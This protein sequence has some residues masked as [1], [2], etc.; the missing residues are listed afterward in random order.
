MVTA[1]W[2]TSNLVAL[3]RDG[4]QCTSCCSEFIP[5]DP[6]GSATDDC[7]CFL[8]PATPAWDAITTFNEGDLVESGGNTYESE[9]DDN[10]NHA[11]GDGD[12]W[13]AVSTNVSCGNADWDS[14]PP[15][16]GPKRTP[17]YYTLTYKITWEDTLDETTFYSNELVATAVDCRYLFS[18]TD[19]DGYPVTV[20]LDIDSWVDVMTTFGRDCVPGDLVGVCDPPDQI[21]RF[22]LE[23]EDCAIVGTIECEHSGPEGPF[24]CCMVRGCSPE[25]F[26]NGSITISWY[27]GQVSEWDSGAGYV[28]G[29]IVAW[30]G[31]FYSCIKDNVNQE[32]PNATY[33]VVI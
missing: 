5:G 18:G 27:P 3:Y 13:T 12:W 20:L 1:A 8:D 16:G 19:S 33:W 14:V 2:D 29:D 9:Q 22:L 17:L 21:Y 26:E 23:I 28:I 24:T 25:N 11:V 6:P 10:L 31:V 7:C 32:P 15:F 30:E 4:V